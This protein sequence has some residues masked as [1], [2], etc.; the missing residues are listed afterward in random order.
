[1]LLPCFFKRALSAAKAAP[2]VAKPSEA[3]KLPVG[4]DEPPLP[5]VFAF[6]SVASPLGKHGGKDVDAIVYVSACCV[7]VCALGVAVG[8]VLVAVGSEKKG[9]G[10]AVSQRGGG[11]GGRGVFVGGR[12][13]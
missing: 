9:R 10:V 8:K 2:A 4:S 6:S 3:S 5:S 13:V 7:G 1:M 11:G 12:G